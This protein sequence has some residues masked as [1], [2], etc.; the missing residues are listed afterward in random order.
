MGHQRPPAGLRQMVLGPRPLGSQPAT[1]S[2]RLSASLGPMDWSPLAMPPLLPTTL[3]PPPLE[4]PHLVERESQRLRKLGNSVPASVPR[5]A[6]HNPYGGRGYP[7]LLGE[8]LYGKPP[9][10]PYSPQLQAQPF[11]A[12]APSLFKIACASSEAPSRT[13]WRSP[14]ASSAGTSSA[15]AWRITIRA[16]RWPSIR[17]FRQALNRSLSVSFT[18]QASSTAASPSGPPRRPRRSPP[19]PLAR[20]CSSRRT[21]PIE[22]PRVGGADT[23]GGSCRGL[24]GRR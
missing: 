5:P 1:L 14:S 24:G 21:A 16:S 17:R 18:L 2:S 10:L 6:F 22:A 12:H 4:F 15:S 20:P 9:L 23:P 19:R 13:S 7:T 11:V 3:P 8:F